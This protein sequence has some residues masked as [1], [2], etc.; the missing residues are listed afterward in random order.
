MLKKIIAPISYRLIKR[1]RDRFITP[2][3]DRADF[4]KDLIQDADKSSEIIIETLSSDKPI[5]IS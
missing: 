1:Y 3:V 2:P 4:E 5:M